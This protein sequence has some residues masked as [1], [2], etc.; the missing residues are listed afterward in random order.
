L[1][2]GARRRRGEEKGGS[3]QPG[4]DLLG[5][6]FEK[7]PPLYELLGRVMGSLSV[8][9]HFCVIEKGARDG[10]LGEEDLPFIVISEGGTTGESVVQ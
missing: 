3:I 2:G 9:G 5:D 1:N 8:S 6:I 10:L 7:K 4:V